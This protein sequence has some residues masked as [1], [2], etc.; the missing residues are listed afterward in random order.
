M[1]YEAREQCPN[2]VQNSEA[3]NTGSEH[4]QQRLPTR[5]A[6]APDLLLFLERGHRAPAL[7]E[8]CRTQNVRAQLLH[9]LARVRRNGMKLVS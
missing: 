6:D 3:E 1:L 5:A 7:G 4:Q 9:G 2:S 8:T